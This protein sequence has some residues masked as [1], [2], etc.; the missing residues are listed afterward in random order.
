MVTHV[1]S[2]FPCVKQRTGKEVTKEEQEEHANVIITDT[3]ALSDSNSDNCPNPTPDATIDF[4]VSASSPLFHREQSLS[5]S[6]MVVAVIVLLV[7]YR[8]LI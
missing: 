2:N 3:E 7:T 5:T 6:L 8:W 4:V 1:G